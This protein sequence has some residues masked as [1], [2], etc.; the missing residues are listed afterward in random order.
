MAND[1]GK[2]EKPEPK[3]RGRKPQWT[4]NKVDI[5]CKAIADGKSYKDAM[6]MAKVGH[7]A[8]YAHLS[9]DADFKERVRKAEADYQELYDATI[10]VEC[11]RSLL[12]LIRG[13][14]YDEVTTETGTDLRG[15]PISKKKVVRKKVAPNP[16][17]II[18]ALCNRDSE[19]WQNRVNNEI[20]GKLDTDVKTDVSLKNVPDAL[21][22]QVLEAI[23]NK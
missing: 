22:A 6:A 1:K 4:Q 11:K 7:T 17:A 8:F 23:K 3:K 2:I 15:K 20:S 13:Y 5:M 9:N 12:E 19:H 18:F 21:L 10:V 14:E 16:T